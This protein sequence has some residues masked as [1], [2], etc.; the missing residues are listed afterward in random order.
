MD[1]GRFLFVV[2]GDFPV[3][4]LWSIFLNLTYFADLLGEL[5]LN[6]TMRSKIKRKVNLICAQN[7]IYS[8]I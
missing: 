7:F 6:K 5:G 1:K 4:Y 8:F 2:T 3:S